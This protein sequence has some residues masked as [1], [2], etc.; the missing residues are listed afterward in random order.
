MFDQALFGE[1]LCQL[2]K[3]MGETQPTLAGILG[4]SIP[5]ISE[6]E[7]GKKGTT[8]EKLT[9]ICEHYG[10]CADYLL[11][12]CDDPSPYRGQEQP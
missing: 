12:L 4:L 7:R 10:V 8:F 5:K 2:R 9:L 11:G 1:R 3:A 6:M